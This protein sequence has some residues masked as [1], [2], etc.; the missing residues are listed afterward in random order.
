MAQSDLKNIQSPRVGTLTLRLPTTFSVG[1]EDIVI[2]AGRAKVYAGGAMIRELRDCIYTIPKNSKYKEIIVD[3]IADVHLV[4]GNPGVQG[5]ATCRYTLHTPTAAEASAVT[6]FHT[7]FNGAGADGV[8]QRTVEYE[9]IH[10]VVIDTASIP[11][12][13]SLPGSVST[14]DMWDWQDGIDIVEDRRAASWTVLEPVFSTI[15]EAWFMYVVCA[16]EYA[17]FDGWRRVCIEVANASTLPRPVVRAALQLPP[18]NPEAGSKTVVG[19]GIEMLS[20]VSQIRVS[21]LYPPLSIANTWIN[22]T[23]HIFGSKL[24]RLVNSQRS[25]TSPV[26]LVAIQEQ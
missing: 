13:G 16:L 6:I 18:E 4:S 21:A 19:F 1:R 2:R 25:L 26:S 24:S 11:A 23:Y 12:D 3:P 15:T 22:G 20:A 17:P 10:N 9:R 8:S 14:S 7:D 5:S